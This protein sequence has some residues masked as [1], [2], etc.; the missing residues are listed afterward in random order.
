MNYKKLVE[1]RKS[2]RDYKKTTVPESVIEEILQFSEEADK[3]IPG[4][5]TEL[6]AKDKSHVYLQLQETA[7]YQGIMIEAPHYLIMLSQ[8]R[9]HYIENAGY[10]GEKIALKA[11]DLGVNT[12]W[13]TFSDSDKIKKRLFLNTD[14]EI[15]AIIALGYDANK[16]RVVNTDSV[17]DNYSKSQLKIVKNNVSTRQKIEDLVYIK[18]WGHNA[19]YEE[20]ENR[21]LLEALNYAR[22]APSTMN[23]QPWRFILDNEKVV[24]TI[25]DDENIREYDEK[26]DT[27]IS[28]LYYESLIGQTLTK[29]KWVLDTPDK[30]YKIP[31]SYRVVGYC[32]I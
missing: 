12:C 28:M 1:E 9:E 7:G 6:L 2:V 20:L 21:G 8:N 26:I 11:L 10:L 23:R 14:K 25:R 27:G 31:D 32:N 5:D 18:E 13:I 15:V 24:L 29:V 17:G 19:T 16:T 22:L 30:D 3:L 4:I